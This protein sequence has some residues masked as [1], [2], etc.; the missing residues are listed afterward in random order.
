MKLNGL[1]AGSKTIPLGGV[2]RKLPDAVPA[3]ESA[4]RNYTDAYAAVRPA[5]RAPGG[6]ATALRMAPQVAANMDAW[7]RDVGAVPLI[8][9]RALSDA[10]HACHLTVVIICAP[11]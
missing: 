6:M 1:V 11:R 3:L 8:P 7:M 5:L 4:L 2:M 9:V 10:S